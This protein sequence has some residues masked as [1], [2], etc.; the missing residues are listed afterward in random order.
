MTVDEIGDCQDATPTEIEADQKRLADQTAELLD[1]QQRDWHLDAAK[2]VLTHPEDPEVTMYIDPFYGSEASFS[3]S[4]VGT[5]GENKSRP[6]RRS[7]G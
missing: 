5:A 4:G 6:A 2:G 7:A 3:S 1:Q